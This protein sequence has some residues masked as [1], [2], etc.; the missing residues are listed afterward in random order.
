MNR[1]AFVLP[2]VA[3]LLC[4]SHVAAMAHPAQAAKQSRQALP[5]ATALNEAEPALAPLAFVQFCLAYDDQCRTA[6]SAR[7][8]VLDAESWNDLARINR[9]IN[10]AITP[11]P[12]KGGSDWSLEVSRGNCNDYAVQ[13]RDALS[14]L[15]YPMTALSLAVVRTAFGEGHLVLT[16]RT[17][18]GDFVLD[19]RRDAVL[20][21][22]RTGYAWVKRQTAQDPE[23]WVALSAGAP[24]RSA[25]SAAKPNTREPV[26]NASGSTSLPEI[27]QAADI[28]SQEAVMQAWAHASPAPSTISHAAAGR[29]LAMLAFDDLG[30]WAT[31]SPSAISRS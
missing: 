11:D 17:D 24:A 18:R 29:R 25:G 2:L 7:P 19:N 4:A 1:P 13:K 26:G 8:L 22:N 31:T 9:E 14:R 5:M 30:G 23:R 3:A 12:D 21:W 10:A 15:G 16:V 6:E 28:A 20:P 27:G